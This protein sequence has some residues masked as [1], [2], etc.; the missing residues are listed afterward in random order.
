MKTVAE[1]HPT[2]AC[3]GRITPI[4]VQLGRSATGASRR[5]VTTAV[6]PPSSPGPAR[7]PRS[8]SNH[9]RMPCA[10]GEPCVLAHTKGFRDPRA[11]P[12]RQRQQYR[13]PSIRLAAVARTR[14]RPE[15][16]SES[17]RRFVGQAAGF[18]LGGAGRRGSRGRPLRHDLPAALDPTSSAL[19]NDS[20]ATLATTT[21]SVD[22]RELCRSPPIR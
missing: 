13:P 4:I 17:H 14:Q 18:C 8:P 10:I 5:G 2:Q 1:H 22:L 11:G 15:C 12:T 6:P 21:D 9:R 20:D 16:L 7:A 19:G 3:D